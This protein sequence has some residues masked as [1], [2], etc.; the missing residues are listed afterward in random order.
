MNVVILA[1]GKGR[2]FNAKAPPE[3]QVLTKCL[4]QL[5]GET[6]LTRQLR[7]LTDVGLTDVTVVVPPE[8]PFNNYDTKYLIDT[9]PHFPTST[10]WSLKKC[11]R[12]FKR[13]G[14]LI[15]MG[16]TVFPTTTLNEVLAVP[17][18]DILFVVTKIPRVWKR[19]DGVNV[20]SKY[21]LD[22]GYMV[23]LK[24]DGVDMFTKYLESAET[25]DG[26]GIHYIAGKM[27]NVELYYPKG[28]IRDVD[29]WRELEEVKEWLNKS[30]E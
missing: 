8:F 17:Y 10:T 24:N 20:P 18:E 14:T 19:V 28:Y 11:V 1:A 7:L 3:Y 12:F 23:L 29:T 4:L 22:E 9:L 13:S 21:G 25:K 6:I 30:K 16:D 5:N 27:R 26:C 2:R 15:L